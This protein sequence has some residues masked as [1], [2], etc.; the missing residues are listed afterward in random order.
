[1]GTGRAERGHV[2]PPSPPSAL[3]APY[4]SPGPASPL[5]SPTRPPTLWRK[6]VRRGSEVGA[7]SH[8]ASSP[9]MGQGL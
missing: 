8:G 1:M 9:R 2:L 3:C 6:W 4:P 7:S 5:P